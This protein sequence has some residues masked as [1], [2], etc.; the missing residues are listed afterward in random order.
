MPRSIELAD[1]LER[2]TV[3][4]HRDYLAALIRC[5][6]AGRIEGEA[7]ERERRAAHDALNLHRNTLRDLLHGLG[8]LPKGLATRAQLGPGQWGADSTSP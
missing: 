1:D 7:G 4:A 5:E 3:A 2:H 8:Y 6:Q